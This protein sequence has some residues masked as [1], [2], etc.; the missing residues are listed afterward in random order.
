MN[1]IIDSH[2]HVCQWTHGGISFIDAYKNYKEKCGL[3]AVNLLSISMTDEDWGA[4]TMAQNIVGAIL[5]YEDE[6]A[7]SYG[8]LFYPRYPLNDFFSAELKSQAEELM[9]IGFDGI[10]MF[11]GKPTLHKKLAY[12]IDKKGYK[13]FF[14]FIEDNS[15]PVNSHVNDPHISWD[16]D[17]VPPSYIE[18]GWFY[19]DGTYATKEQIYDEVYRVLD[20]FGGI[21][22]TFAHGFFMGHCPD[23][24]AKIMDK[25]PN[26][27]IDLAPGPVFFKESV[28]HFDE[29]KSFFEKYYDRILFG[30]DANNLNNFDTVTKNLVSDVYR[31]YA[32]SDE[33]EAFSYYDS[34]CTLRGLGLSEEKCDAISYKNFSD[35][36][37]EKPKK[38]DRV[39][40]KR[41]IEKFLPYM[42]ENDT[43]N[44]IITYYKEYL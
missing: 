14:R 23:E 37:G 32:T 44:S 41:Y 33:Y 8:G 27:R 30:T 9:A 7:Y 29:F 18:N 39:L 26:T 34:T 15:I 12:G 25:Y 3:D 28:G 35:M 42:P 1:K 6:T 21:N 31:F 20:R 4:F 43:K 24:L 5:K 16:R 19:G 38:I 40:L 17:K 11:E 10:K 13:A 2:C 36:A 22:I